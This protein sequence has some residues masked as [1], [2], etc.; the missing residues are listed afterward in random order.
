MPDCRR[1]TSIRSVRPRSSLSEQGSRWDYRG[2]P[3][4]S[5]RGQTCGAGLCAWHPLRSDRRGCA[6]SHRRGVLVRHEGAPRTPRGG[7]GPSDLDHSMASTGLRLCRS[8]KRSRATA[9]TTT[10]KRVTRSAG[11]LRLPSRARARSL[12]SRAGARARCLSRAWL[13]RIRAHRPDAL[14][15]RGGTH[16][17]RGRRDSGLHR[18]VAVTTGGRGGGHLVRRDRAA[19][20]GPRVGPCTVLESRRALRSGPER[21]S[22]RRGRLVAAALKVL[23]RHLVEELLELVHDFFRVLDLVLELDRRLRDHVLRR[24]DWSARPHC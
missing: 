16:R 18:D 7:A 23:R 3:R 5:G 12:P 13:L 20:P 15:R 4:L 10:S 22:R 11:P 19:G 1:L 24:E 17:S 8:W 6:G 14:E 2:A 9:T 21:T